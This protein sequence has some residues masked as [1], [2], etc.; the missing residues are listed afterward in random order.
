M[1]VVNPVGVRHRMIVRGDAVRVGR[2]GM[3]VGWEAGLRCRQRD[4]LRAAGHARH[5]ERLIVW[6]GAHQ[7]AARPVRYPRAA[8]PGA[9]VD[10]VMG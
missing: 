2:A 8:H 7:D 6:L 5:G 10:V 4:G 3:V 1:A 9:G